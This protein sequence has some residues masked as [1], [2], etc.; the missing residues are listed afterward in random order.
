MVPP[1]NKKECVDKSDTKTSEKDKREPRRRMSQTTTIIIGIVVPLLLSGFLNH[2]A[3]KNWIL[4]F[5]VIGI[6][7]A[8]IYFGHLGI[9]SLN[10]S[11]VS[12]KEHPYLNFRATRLKPLEVGNYP[13]IEYQLENMS[14]VEVSVLIKDATCQFIQDAKQTSFQSVTSEEARFTMVPTKIIY[15]Q[16]RFPK[17]ILTEDEIK[18]L[19]QEPERGR[20]VFYARGEYK[21]IAGGPTYAFRFC[22]FYNP[23]IDGNLIICDQGITFKEPENGNK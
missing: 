9:K 6:A 13:V 7:L 18:A 12:Q 15:G 11:N 20:L 5:P 21:D 17:H 2:F 3:H 22:Q 16:I 10:K 4:Y 1:S 14:K 23:Y 19:N 8:V